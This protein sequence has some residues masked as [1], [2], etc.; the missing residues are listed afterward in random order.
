MPCRWRILDQSS[1]ITPPQKREGIRTT[2]GAGQSAH[3][4]PGSCHL[5]LAEGGLPSPKATVCCAFT[6]LGSPFSSLLTAALHLAA[7]EAI[8]AVYPSP[9]HPARQGLPAKNGAQDG[10]FL[11]P[12]SPTKADGPGADSIWA[13]ADPGR[14][15]F[16][17][18]WELRAQLDA[19]ARAAA[20]AQALAAEA[21]KQV[22]AGRWTG[23]SCT[24]AAGQRTC[25]APC[26]L[27]G[28]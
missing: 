9:G 20:G 13:K 14:P 21:V 19:V 24:S 15:V 22:T 12:L 5:W 25:S 1:P 27:T 2:V 28:N 6:V 11:P 4:M 26:C 17:D 10:A 7:V 8:P 16:A 3:T 18:S 23:Q